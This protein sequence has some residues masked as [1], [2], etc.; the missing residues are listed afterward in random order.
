MT[1]PC[2]ALRPAI[3]TRSENRVPDDGAED[4]L[5]DCRLPT[6]MAAASVKERLDD[7]PRRHIGDGAEGQ[8]RAQAQMRGLQ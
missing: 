4:L 1:L 8:G 3:G 5:Y 6:I 7:M 2:N